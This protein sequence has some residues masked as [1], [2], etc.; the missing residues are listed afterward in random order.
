[1]TS[2]ST[3]TSRSSSEDVG[4]SMMTSLALKPIARA[5]AT[6]CWV[7]VLK[8]ISGRRTSTIDLEPGEQRARLVVHRLPV[9]Q[10]EAAAFAAE[11]DVLG[12]RA[13]GDEIDLLID[14]ADALGLRVLRRTRLEGARRRRRSR[15]R[16]GRHSRSG[17]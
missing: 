8:R 14:R 13:I 7:A 17:S 4:S 3:L 16:R 2:N 12:D 11:A 1:M 10:A 6:I 15:R 5:I 9:E